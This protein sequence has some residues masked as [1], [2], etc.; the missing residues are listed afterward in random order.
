MSLLKLTA[1]RSP[2]RNVEAG[3]G[4]WCERDLTRGAKQE[5]QASHRPFPYSAGLGNGRAFDEIG[6][7]A[8]SYMAYQ[9]EVR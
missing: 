7:S 5:G 6:G 3:H 2:T 4:R 1:N 9:R 8:I